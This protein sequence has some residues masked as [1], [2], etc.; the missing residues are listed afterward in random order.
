M[1]HNLGKTLGHR[2][3]RKRRAEEPQ[4]HALGR[5]RGGFGGKLHLC[6]DGPGFPLAVKVTTGQQHESTQ[7]EVLMNAVRIPRAQDRPLRAR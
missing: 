1:R 3:E 5:S 2:Y 4:D 7:L 6:T